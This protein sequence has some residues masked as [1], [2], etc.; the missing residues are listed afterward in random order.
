[1]TTTATSVGKIAGTRRFRLVGSKMSYLDLSDKRARTLAC[2]AMHLALRT[3]ARFRR[4]ADT[5]EFYCDAIFAPRYVTIR[6]RIKVLI[7]RGHG[8]LSGRWIYAR[9][10]LRD[11]ARSRGVY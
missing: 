4:H 5:S 11:R 3:R 9:S 10:F 6:T 8:C 7:K 2:G 1:M